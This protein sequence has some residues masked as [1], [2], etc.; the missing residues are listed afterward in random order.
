[1]QIPCGPCLNTESVGGRRAE[2]QQLLA[3]LQERHNSSL[4][5]ARK[6]APHKAAAAAEAACKALAS[7]APRRAAKVSAAP[8]QAAVPSFLGPKL[9]AILA[10]VAVTAVVNRQA[11]LV[12]AVGL[13]LDMHQL[14]SALVTHGPLPRIWAA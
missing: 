12:R 13:L 9:L 3:D 14:W 4:V 2:L 6:G 7:S 5:G 11:L 10:L 8:G 1:M